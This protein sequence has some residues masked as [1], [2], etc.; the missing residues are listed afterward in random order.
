MSLSHQKKNILLLHCL[1]FAKCINTIFHSILHFI[2][3]KQH[4][5]KSQ[6][7]LHYLHRKKRSPNVCSVNKS[8]RWWTKSRQDSFCCCCCL[9][10]LSLQLPKHIIAAEN[11][12]LKKRRNKDGKQ[13]KKNWIS[14]YRKKKTELVKQQE[15]GKK[16][17]KRREM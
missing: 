13:C 10:C 11:V 16:K 5:M 1:M 2:Q 14:Q 7:I 3:K 4:K 8:Y 12:C 6:H 9:C 17:E 15:N